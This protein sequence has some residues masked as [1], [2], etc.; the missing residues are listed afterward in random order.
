[1]LFVAIAKIFTSLRN[2]N[3]SFGKKI[4]LNKFTLA[5]HLLTFTIFLSVSIF[6]LIELESLQKD[7]VTVDQIMK[8]AHSEMIAGSA[9]VLSLLFLQSILF[10]LVQPKPTQLSETQRN[11]E[12]LKQVLNYDDQAQLWNAYT[13]SDPIFDK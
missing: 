12:I 3:S 2:N 4:A 5:A 13:P 1:M 6:M 9:S 11:K 8:T 10:F 7:T